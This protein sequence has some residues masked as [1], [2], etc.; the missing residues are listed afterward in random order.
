MVTL[1]FAMR[2]LDHVVLRVRDLERALAFYVGVLGC[3]PTWRR[4]ALG[5]VHLRAGATTMIDLVA[6][7]GSLGQKGG[8]GPER[9]GRNVDHLCLQVGP[10]DAAAIGAHLA[11]HGVAFGS[12]APRNFG[13]EGVGPSLYVEDPDGN[14]V[15]LKGP[16]LMVIEAAVELAAPPATVWRWLTE[17]DLT[18]RYWGGTRI[19]SPWR[20][21]ATITYRREGAVTDEHVVLAIEA[22]RLLVQTFHPLAAGLRDEAPSRVRF[23]LRESPRGTLLGLRHDGFPADSAVHRACARGWPGILEALRAALAG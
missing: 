4:E 19:E 5:L 8:R 22:P 13:A 17:P 1:P 2:G 18:E 6:L 3:V 16:P 10:F 15:E 11:E 23:T 14:T 20:P 7:D 9:E 12:V 21:G